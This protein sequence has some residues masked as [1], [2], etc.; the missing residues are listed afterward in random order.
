MK[1]KSFQIVI[2]AIV[3]LINRFQIVI[4]VKQVENLF[5]ELNVARRTVSDFYSAYC[6][7]KKDL[8]FA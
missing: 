7:S 8:A 4:A 2:A 3:V 5:D 1:W 6:V